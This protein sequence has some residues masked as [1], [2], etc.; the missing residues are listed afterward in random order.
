M[1]VLQSLHGLAL[2]RTTY[3]VRDRLS[4]MRFC[5]LGPGDQRG[6]L[7]ADVGADR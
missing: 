2:G 3:L 4:W 7:F 5:G 1:L 6:R